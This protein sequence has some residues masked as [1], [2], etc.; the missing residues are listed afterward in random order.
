M[1]NDGKQDPSCEV[2]TRFWTQ[3]HSIYYSL[4]EAEAYTDFVIA[5]FKFIPVQIRDLR[6]LFLMIFKLTVP[7]KE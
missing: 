6:I 4:W 3:I 2:C 7:K 5:K 1:N